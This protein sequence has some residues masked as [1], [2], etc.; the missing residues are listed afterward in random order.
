MTGNP[1]ARFTGRAESYQ[2]ARPGYPKQIFD[3]LEHGCG[4]TTGSEIVDIAAGT[5]ILTDLLLTHG[6]PVTAVEPNADMRAVCVGL[7]VNYPELRVIDGSAED[8]TLASQSADLLT[9]AQALHWFDLPRARKEFAR[10]LRPSGFCVIL[11]NERLS[12][13][14]RFN[15][16]Y[17]SLMQSFGSDYATVQ[18]RKLDP[19]ALT[20][21]FAPKAVEHQNVPNTQTLNREGLVERVRSS[22][23]MPQPTDPV[24]PEMLAAIDRLFTEC[25][26][27]G[28]VKMEYKCH[29]SYGK[30]S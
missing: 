21:F 15:E 8:T 4:L 6:N 24:Y 29:L 20:G 28:Y 13:G 11:Y 30:L 14:S 26:Q 12:M 17:E 7:Q 9:V 1:Q 18:G 22:S 27:N 25:H 3:I 19:A 5:G 16:Q 10:I 23:Y 2:A